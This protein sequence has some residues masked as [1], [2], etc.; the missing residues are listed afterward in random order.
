MPV[1]Q[2]VGFIGAGMMAEA[3]ASGFIS[4]GVIKAEQVYCNDPTP[5]RQEV[6]KKMGA[7]PLNSGKEVC[8]LLR[9][10]SAPA[11][12]KRRRSLTCFTAD[13]RRPAFDDAHSICCLAR[14]SIA[15]TCCSFRT[16]LLWQGS[17]QVCFGAHGNGGGGSL[18]RLVPQQLHTQ[19]VGWPDRNDKHTMLMCV[20]AALRPLRQT[21]S[22]AASR[23]SLLTW[24][25]LTR[26]SH[27]QVCEKVDILFVATKPQYVRQVLSENQ[28]VLKNSLVVSI[29]AGVTI[30]TLLEALGTQEAKVI[31]VMPNTPCLVGATAAAMAAGARTLATRSAPFPCVRLR[32]RSFAA[33][34]VAAAC[35]TN[36]QH[37]RVGL[38]KHKPT[39]VQH[40][41]TV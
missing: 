26:F 14:V 12:V 28:A 34:H 38:T 5:A 30:A 21:C 25:Y 18:R 31:R 9:H 41:R 35:S 22:S 29:A 39:G 8:S 17:A 16:F 19:A 6:F 10:A 3:L 36:P 13:L 20:T 33:V 7:N 15:Q 27:V 11:Q 24:A 1:S 32:V 40:K 4:K 23:A 2:T 37:R